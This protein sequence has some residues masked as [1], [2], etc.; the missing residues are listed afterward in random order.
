MTLTETELVPPLGGVPV[1]PRQGK[2]RR[3]RS[4]GATTAALLMVGVAILTVIL[5]P[6]AAS[7]NGAELLLGP[8]LPLAFAS[9]AQMLIILV[10]DFDL[11]V[12]YA[13]GL[14]NVFSA[15]LLTT[16]VWLG[17]LV[18]FGIVLA[19]V[20]MGAIVQIFRVPAIVVT[21]GASFIWL[22]IGLTVQPTPG[23]T[24]SNWLLQ[25]TNAT[26]PV[27][28]ETFYILV[29]GAVFSWWL[30]KRWRYGIVLRGLG[31]NHL[32]LES[33]GWSV[34]RTRLY[35][36]ALAGVMVVIAGMLT[37]SVTTS[38]D[39][40]ASA[41]LTLTTF[42]VVVIGGCRFQ[43]GVVEPAGVVAAAVALSLLAS[44]LAFL[45]VTP[46]WDTAV[47]GLVLVAAVS[48][49]WVAEQVRRQVRSR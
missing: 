3:L 10:G 25:I 49:K 46:A 4:P 26:W 41:T 27:L 5:R 48:T 18:L 28:P 9:L 23:G 29:A 11:S 17:V 30:I 15:T 16:N 37:T 32:A 38:A 31:N 20:A 2:K 22:G 21:L 39:I 12:G 33:S 13:V 47:E 7:S 42:A 43:G 35:A 40:N 34:L 14:A 44:T 1:T 19:Y 36:Y 6:S 45:N 24:S 8:A